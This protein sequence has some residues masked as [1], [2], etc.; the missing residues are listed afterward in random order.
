LRKNFVRLPTLEAER[1]FE[2]DLLSPLTFVRK[3]KSEEV[4]MYRR[5]TSKYI[6][7]GEN[8]QVK[9]AVVGMQGWRESMEDAHI[10]NSNLGMGRSLFAVFD[11]HAGS[12]VAKFCADK[13]CTVLARLPSFKDH[14]Y[15]DALVECFL[16]LDEIMKTKEG[17]EELKILA[18]SEEIFAGTTA[19]V[20]LLTP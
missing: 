11:G 2:E 18:Q 16:S 9:Y 5:N 6:S 13:F 4:T 3:V 19:S 15:K 20:V 1:E 10:T 7:T 14:R 12:E 17:I 8:W